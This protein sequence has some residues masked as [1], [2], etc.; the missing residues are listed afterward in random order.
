MVERVRPRSGK[1]RRW[2][3]DSD[4]VPG[5]VPTYAATRTGEVALDPK[6]TAV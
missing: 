4:A 3:D 2:D 5:A 1:D 6:E